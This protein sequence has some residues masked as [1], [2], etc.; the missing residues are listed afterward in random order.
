M[1]EISIRAKE[2]S[3][4]Y[5]KVTFLQAMEK[6]LPDYILQRNDYFVM[7]FEK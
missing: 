4:R 1:E 6:G 2:S 7:L 5:R 3:V